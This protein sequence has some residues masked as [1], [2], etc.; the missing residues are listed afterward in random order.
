[1]MRAVL[2]DSGRTKDGRRGTSQ[3]ESAP[4]R[5]PSGRTSFVGSLSV[6]ALSN[7]FVSDFFQCYELVILAS[8]CAIGPSSTSSHDQL[9]HHTPQFT[10]QIQQDAPH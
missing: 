2:P 9:V 3:V 1:M 10:G 5:R 4:R 7:M 6:T 8:S